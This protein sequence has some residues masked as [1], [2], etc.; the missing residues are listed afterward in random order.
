V[1]IT[2]SNMSGKT[3]FVRAL[4]A[5]AVLAQ[6]VATTRASIWRAPVF[7]I[8]TSIGQSDSLLEGKSY[9]LA[10]VESVRRMLLSKES[11]VQHLFLLDELFRGTNTSERVAAG[12]AT[13]AWLHRGDD[14]VVVATH[15]VELHALLGDTYEAYHFRE[16]VQ[17]GALTFDYR[18]QPGLSSTRNAIALLEVMRFPAGLVADARSA[19]GHRADAGDGH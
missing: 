3:T 2:G 16:Q 9:Y 10:E 1:L 12:Y 6:S 5:N 8:R 17:D 4:G 14:L 13:L 11:G 15:D 7:R 19:L 18:V